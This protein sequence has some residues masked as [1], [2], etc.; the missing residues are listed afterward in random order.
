MER[1]GTLLDEL[2]CGDPGEL[3]IERIEANAANENSNAS[4]LGLLTLMNDYGARLGWQFDPQGTGE[5]GQLR[6]YAVLELA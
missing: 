6:T 1:F 3:L 5:T 2:A 4:G